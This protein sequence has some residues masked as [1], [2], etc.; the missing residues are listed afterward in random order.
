VSGG[1]FIVSPAIRDISRNVVSPIPEFFT[2]ALL[3]IGMVGLIGYGWR[4]GGH[5]R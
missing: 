3:G 4:R 5:D 1:I 2:L